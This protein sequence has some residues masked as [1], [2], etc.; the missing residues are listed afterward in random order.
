MINSKRQQILNDYA[1]TITRRNQLPGADRILF[2][3]ARKDNR[4]LYNNN[5]INPIDAVEYSAILYGRQPHF[6][7]CVCLKL[8]EKAE[9]LR[10]SGY[11]YKVNIELTF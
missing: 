5:L 10:A 4:L 6:F 9:S 3:R 1:E 2:I 8:A 7:H 11:K